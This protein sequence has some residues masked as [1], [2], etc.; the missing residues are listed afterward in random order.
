MPL[1]LL[2][3]LLETL[4]VSPRKTAWQNVL[5]LQPEESIAAMLRIERRLDEE[6]D[7][8]TFGEDAGFVLFATRNGKVK[9]TEQVMEMLDQ[10]LWRAGVGAL[11]HFA[12][13]ILH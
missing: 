6:G 11:P 10:L 2:K 5:N 9:K 4:H 1:L 12:S 8:V 3:S 13:A 7:D